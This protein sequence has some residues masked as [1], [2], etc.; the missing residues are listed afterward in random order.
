MQP[1]QCLEPPLDLLHF[2]PILRGNL[3]VY[4]PDRLAVK[5]FKVNTNCLDLHTYESTSCFC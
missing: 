5:L 4:E 2:N 3:I 1:H